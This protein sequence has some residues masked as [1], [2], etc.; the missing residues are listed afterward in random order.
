MILGLALL[1]VALALSGLGIT[2]ALLRIGAAVEEVGRAL[3]AIERG[4]A[5]RRMAQL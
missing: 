4:D 1:T 5:Y 3:Y 2:I